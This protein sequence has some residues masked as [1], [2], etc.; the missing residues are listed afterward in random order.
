E[1]RLAQLRK[2]LARQEQNPPL[3]QPSRAGRGH[4]HGSPLAREGIARVR[5]QPEEDRRGG[6]RE[7]GFGV[8]S[9]ENR[10]SSRRGGIWKIFRPTNTYK[11]TGRVGA[12][13]AI[14]RRR[15][16]THAGQD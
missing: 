10:G 16:K 2:I 4:G 1:P 5:P 6:H 13:F 14:R 15:H 9:F 12:A 3:D 8:W 7:G 11:D